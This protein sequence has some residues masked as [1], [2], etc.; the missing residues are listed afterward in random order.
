M[1]VSIYAS[2]PIVILYKPCLLAELVSQRTLS[3]GL[4]QKSMSWKVNISII[5][6]NQKSSVLAVKDTYKLFLQTLLD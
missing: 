2:I 3:M 6:L 1:I 5:S 4:I